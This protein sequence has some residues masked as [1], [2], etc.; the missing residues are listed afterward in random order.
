M[1]VTLKGK[2]KKKL[3]F[4]NKA[5]SDRDALPIRLPICLGPSILGM[6]RKGTTSFK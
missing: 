6:A 5:L 1:G 2:D 3:D 4:L